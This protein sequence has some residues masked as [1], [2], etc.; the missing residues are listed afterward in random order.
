[1]SC[2]HVTRKAVCKDCGH[3]GECVESADDWNRSRTRWVGFQEVPPSD[4]AIYRKRYDADDR[5][6][7][8]ACGSRD[9]SVGEILSER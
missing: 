9:I 2:Q 6:P 3:Q 1:M 5:L 7:V 8:C 4:M